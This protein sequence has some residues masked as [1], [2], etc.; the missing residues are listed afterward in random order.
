MNVTDN[1]T[2]QRAKPKSRFHFMSKAE[3]EM[4][5]LEEVTRQPKKAKVLRKPVTKTQKSD[6]AEKGYWVANG[7]YNLRPETIESYFYAY[8]ITGD[9]KY[10]QWAWDAFEGIMEHAT[11]NYGYAALK[12][13]NMIAR[14]SD[15]ELGKAANQRDYSESFWSAEVLKYLYLIFS[16]PEKF[17]IDDWVFNTEAH[18]FRKIIGNE[19]D[20]LY[21]KKG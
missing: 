11:A 13:V 16:D 5:E 9:K 12:S 7:N 20:A 4:V 18:P 21:A 10:Q 15:G 3:K 14:D 8:R 17:S 19:G 6:L 2:S 1:P